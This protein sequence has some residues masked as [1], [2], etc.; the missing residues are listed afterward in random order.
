VSKAHN[1]M[2]YVPDANP[3]E[4]VFVYDVKQRLKRRYSRGSSGAQANARA[5]RPYLN[6]TG[7]QVLFDSA[8]SNYDA[9]DGNGVA[10]VFVRPNPLA[11]FVVFGSGFD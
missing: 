7:T 11:E 4:S 6:Y 1:L 10:D 2:G 8:A 3:H 9:G 5:L